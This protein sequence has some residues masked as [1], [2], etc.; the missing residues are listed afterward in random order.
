MAAMTGLRAQAWLESD[1][2][3]SGSSRMVSAKEVL[4]K[5][6]DLL[7]CSETSAAM[8]TLNNLISKKAMDKPLIE[9]EEWDDVCE[10]SRRQAAM[11]EDVKKQGWR[12]M[13][14]RRKA[15]SAQQ[16]SEQ[17]TRAG[18]RMPW[19]FGNVRSVSSGAAANSKVAGLFSVCPC[20]SSIARSRS[21]SIFDGEVEDFPVK[22]PDQV[23]CRTPEMEQEDVWM[24]R[25]GGPSDVD[26]ATVENP[27]DG[28]RF[29]TVDHRAEEDARNLFDCLNRLPLLK[30]H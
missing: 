2:Q 8:D 27:P 22:L 3:S 19:L 23:R 7:A 21:R 13:G 18:T 17:A 30:H 16:R 1:S 24:S 6:V 26:L 29:A 14:P 5:I 20:P 28:P 4:Q 10:M 11:V 12:L 25:S 15:G 9:A